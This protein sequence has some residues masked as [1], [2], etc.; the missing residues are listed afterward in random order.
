M[1]AIFAR[2]DPQGTGSLPP[3]AYSSFPEVGLFGR[4]I[5]RQSLNTDGREDFADLILRICLDG[6]SVEYALRHRA[7][8]SPT[9]VQGGPGMP[10]LTRQ[11]FI[12]LQAIE[13][14]SEPDQAVD[15]L[16]RVLAHYGIWQT[17]GPLPRSIL[18]T[19][20]PQWV[21]ERFTKAEAHMITHQQIFQ[22]QF[23]YQQQQQIQQQRQNQLCQ[24][25]Q[26]Q[27][28][29]ALLASMRRARYEA[30]VRGAMNAINSVVM[31]GGSYYHQTWRW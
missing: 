13:I 28:I 8:A 12:D 26:D 16:N 10:S 2:L 7:H 11:G 23:Q 24:M 25:Q 30:D 29:A 27:D 19:H 31:P 9:F 21:I 15:R 1:D 14:L 5:W 4:D 20:P 22:Q 18:P 17:W 6:F 3:E